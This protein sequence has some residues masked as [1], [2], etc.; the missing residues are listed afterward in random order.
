MAAVSLLLKAQRLV[1]PAAFFFVPKCSFPLT[2]VP[3]HQRK[4]R[5]RD[6]ATSRNLKYDEA[7]NNRIAAASFLVLLRRVTSKAAMFG[8]HNATFAIRR[9]PS[10]GR[11]AP[12]EAAEQT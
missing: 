6:R 8:S 3:P 5:R 1:K 11:L 2:S 7:S 9:A 4:S 12:Q 10:S